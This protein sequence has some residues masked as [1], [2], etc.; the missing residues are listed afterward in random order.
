MRLDWTLSALLAASLSQ[1]QYLI[2]ELSFGHAG[3]IS[4]PSSRGQ[5]TNFALQGNPA[6]PEVLSNRIILTPLAPGNQRGAIWAQQ[7]LQRTQWIADFDFRANGPERG[8]GNLNIWLVRGGP[9]VVSSSSVYTV[10]KFDG[11]VLTIDK[12]GSSGGIIRG[13]LNDG[14]TDYSAK[15]RVEE[16][17]FG[18]CNYAYRNLGRPSQ[19]KMRQ[20]G[21]SFRVEVDGNLCFETDKISIPQGY[22]FGITAATPDVPDSFEVFKMVVMSDNSDSGSNPNNNQQQSQQQSSNR[23]NSNAKKDSYDGGELSDED[24]DIFQTSKAQ[25]QD[26]HN[27]LQ[28][29]NHQLSALHRTASRHQ[30][31]DEKRH[32]EV[33]QLIGQLRADL[34]KIDEIG[35]L[36][37]RITELNREVSELRREV[38]RKLQANERSVRGL[39]DTHH[40]SLTDAVLT[41]TPGHK[42][43]ILCFLGTQGLLVAAFVAYKRRRAA[44]PKKYL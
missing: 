1:A 19:V 33:T 27:R 17:A 4:D 31:Q 42:F 23:V 2:S 37:S 29:T 30:Q 21:R 6:V 15:Q 20:T 13:F 34:R 32:D 18:H 36:Q 26:L 40:S 25:F 41:S 16:L 38:S 44:M 24:P 12:T 35:E 9:G 5:I 3:R 39:L 14:S 8:G 28:N 11:F 22:Q 7:P 43:L 10:G